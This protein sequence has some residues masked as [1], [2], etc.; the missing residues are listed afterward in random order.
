MEIRIKFQRPLGPRRL[1]CHVNATSVTLASLTVQSALTA[2][3][4]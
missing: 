1:Y 2:C 4:R 3:L